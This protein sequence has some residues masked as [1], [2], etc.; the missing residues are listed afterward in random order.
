M[1]NNIS[2]IFIYFNHYLIFN[3]INALFSHYIL[4]INN[5]TTS[6]V[7]SKNSINK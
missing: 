4:H 2:D 5:N 3:L 6:L 7:S 1:Y